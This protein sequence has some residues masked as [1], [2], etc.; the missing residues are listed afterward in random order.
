VLTLSDPAPKGSALVA[1]ENFYPGWR[2]TVDG[3]P[4]TA[5][6]ADLT[7][8]GVPLPQGAKKVELEFSSDA[9]ERGKAITLAAIALSIL[10][11]LAGLFVPA[12]AR[13]SPATGSRT[14]ERA[15]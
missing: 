10:S 14:A 13:G 5:E 4:V 8:I 2:A 7:L 12:P 9:Y 11:A 6:R 3:K 15:A 1:S